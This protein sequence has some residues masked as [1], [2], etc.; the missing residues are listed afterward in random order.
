MLTAIK[1]AK[2]NKEK[3]DNAEDDGSTAQKTRSEDGTLLIKPVLI[4]DHPSAERSKPE[5]TVEGT[6]LVDK[7]STDKSNAVKEG[8]K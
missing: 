8:T 5:T 4:S 3:Q 7:N 2:K 6:F 1:N